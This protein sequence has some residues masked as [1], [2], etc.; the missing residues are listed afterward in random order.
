MS[1]Q[2]LLSI[3]FYDNHTQECVKTLESLAQWKQDWEVLLITEEESLPLWFKEQGITGKIIPK[4]P[5]ALT[6]AL[7]EC[8]GAYVAISRSGMVYQKNTL[9]KLRGLRTQQKESILLL[10]AAYQ[11]NITHI[12]QHNRFYKE[13]VKG[14]SLEKDIRLCHYL[15][16][17]FLLPRNQLPKE[18][19]SYEQPLLEIW[20]LLYKTVTKENRIYSLEGC[21]CQVSDFHDFSQFWM[22]IQEEEKN[23]RELEGFLDNLWNWTICQEQVNQEHGKY[24]LFHYLVL[25]AIQMDKGG[26]TKEP[27]AL[28]W[29]EDYLE[30][31]SC[32]ELIASDNYLPRSFKN[33]LL[34]KKGYISDCSQEIQEKMGKVLDQSQLPLNYH[35]LKLEEHAFRV[36]GSAVTYDP[37][38]S[39]GYFH[40]GKSLYPCTDTKWGERRYWF[41]VCVERNVHFQCRISYSYLSEKSSLGFFF[42]KD[43]KKEKRCHFTF[44]PY[45]PLSEECFLFYEKNGWFLYHEEGNSALTIEKS[46]FFRRRQLQKLQDQ[47]LLQAGEEEAVRLQEEY[48]KYFRVPRKKIWLISDGIDRADDNGEAFWK[49]FKE[50]P[51]KG[52]KPYFVIRQDSVDYD[53]VKALGEV[54]EPLSK[55]HL[56]LHLVSDYIISS[57]ANEPVVNP[58]GAD[59]EYFKNILADKKIV[60]LQHGVIHTDLF[61]WM[62]RYNRNFYG[63]VTTTKPE[64]EVILDKGD[65]RQEQ[66]WPVGLSRYDLLYHDEKKQITIIPTWRQNLCQSRN[67]V[68]GMRTVAEDFRSSRYFQFYNG[69]LNH[70]RILEEA[71]KRGYEICFHLHPIFYPCLPEFDRNPQV[72]FL[73]Q[74]KPYREIFA[75]AD[76]L[77]TDYSSIAFDFAYLRKPLIYCQFDAEEFFG[78]G[79]SVRKGYFDYERDGFGEV[80]K[81]LEETV[82]TIIS[83]M[84]NQCVLKPEY[85]ARIEKTFSYRDTNCRERLM[86]RLLKP[87]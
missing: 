79:H 62:N 81:T 11:E 44:G 41:G 6:K 84:E 73:A 43:E 61:R 26:G 17:A 1:D 67:T 53:R 48:R 76:L 15:Y 2:P 13:A 58:A 56:F 37:E 52:V 16:F 40:I 85:E 29:A 66:I 30:R 3:I 64:T 47:S 27:E 69:L 19:T 83:Y 21:T 20:E 8:R 33:Y 46:S 4:G 18:L 60:F 82:D 51:V 77:V 25:Y 57:Q 59:R 23:R 45:A 34:K 31:L 39:Q 68:T 9:D 38:D 72:T 35:F 86:Q 12:R 65:Y 70:P 71:G 22:H 75:E 54:I 32:P 10:P 87:Y 24:N 78:G 28:T 42:K 80:T 63:L 36:E 49:Y 5:G 50:H 74:G 14:C 55:E 7:G